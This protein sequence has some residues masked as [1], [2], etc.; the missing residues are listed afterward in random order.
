MRNSAK[1]WYSIGFIYYLHGISD[2]VLL[3]CFLSQ[4]K[5][6]R[7]IT[8]LCSDFYVTR[9]LSQFFYQPTYLSPVCFFR[10]ILFISYFIRLLWLITNVM[11]VCFLLAISQSTFLVSVFPN[12]FFCSMQVL[13]F[14]PFPNFFHHIHCF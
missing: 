9:S 5:Y 13:C 3:C 14:L 4:T 1:K 8:V 10:I 2:F 11:V 12:I 6:Y 7:T